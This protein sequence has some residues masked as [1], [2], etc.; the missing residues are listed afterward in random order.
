[1]I[2]IIGK[3]N[4]AKVFTDTADESTFNTSARTIE[5]RMS[6]VTTFRVRV[7]DIEHCLVLWLS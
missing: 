7:S 6:I 2:E 4:T 5:A 3:Y 1:M